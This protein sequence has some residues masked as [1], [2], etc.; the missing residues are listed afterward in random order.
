M[1]YRVRF[2]QSAQRDADRLLVRI[3]EAAP[4]QGPV[5]YEGLIS[6][7]AALEYLPKRCPVVPK[8]SRGEAEV[9]Q[10]L[11]GRKPYVYR[12]S[13]LIQRDV[14]SILRIHGPGQVR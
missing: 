3:T 12:V 11:F 1:A 5:W 6:A 8:A 7:V 9:R 4:T 2:L 10:L 13:F 14:V